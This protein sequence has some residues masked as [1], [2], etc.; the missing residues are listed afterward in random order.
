MESFSP[1]NTEP[2]ASRPTPNA[3]LERKILFYS[4][5]KNFELSQIDCDMKS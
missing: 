5:V 2:T 1:E 3:L 4:N